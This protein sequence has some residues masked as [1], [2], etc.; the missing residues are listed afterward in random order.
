MRTTV[1]ESEPL[2][3]ECKNNLRIR[4]E[5]IPIHSDD[6]EIVIGTHGHL[7]VG[8]KNRHYPYAGILIDFSHPLRRC[9]GNRAVASEQREGLSSMYLN[10]DR[11]SRIH[12][13]KKKRTALTSGSPNV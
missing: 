3:I 2:G 6:A 4:R 8:G 10:I 5:I 1:Q 13:A 12:E 7:S 9:D 11:F